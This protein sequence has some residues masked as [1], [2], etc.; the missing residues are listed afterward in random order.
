[1]LAVNA[2]CCVQ[3]GRSAPLKPQLRY[4]SERLLLKYRKFGDPCDSRKTPNRLIH[5]GL[6]KA[7][8]LS[9][10]VFQYSLHS[11]SRF[12]QSHSFCFQ[13]VKHGQRWFQSNQTS[14]DKN[15]LVCFSGCN[16]SQR[17]ASVGSLCL[18]V[19]SPFL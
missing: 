9:L 1:M 13:T 14:T 2:G 4:T 5:L 3:S 6:V 11:L 12:F 8:T 19:G 10:A 16:P 17:I 7:S 15:T 18:L